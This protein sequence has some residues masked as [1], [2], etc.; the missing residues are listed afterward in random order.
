EPERREAWDR[1]HGVSSRGTASSSGGPFAGG[2]EA[3][4]TRG[5]PPRPRPTRPVTGRVDASAVFRPGNAV[6][7]PPGLRTTLPGHPP[8]SGSRFDREPLRA[9]QPCG[10][11][12]RRAGSRPAARPSVAEAMALPLDFGRF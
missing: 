11:V 5:G 6:T 4:E 1:I 7:T 9:S 8:R 12:T 10:P 3:Y 2:A